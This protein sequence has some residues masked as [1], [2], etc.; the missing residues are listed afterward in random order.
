MKQTKKK[1]EQEGKN[2]F[3][4]DSEQGSRNVTLDSQSRLSTL[5][6]QEGRK[7][8]RG[9]KL[10]LYFCYIYIPIFFKNYITSRLKKYQPARFL[11]VG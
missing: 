6:S 2:S 4:E 11:L 1:K 3:L 10:N 8:E 9:G 7:G 5:D